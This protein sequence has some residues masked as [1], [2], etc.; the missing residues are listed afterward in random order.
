MNIRPAIICLLGSPSSGKSTII[1]KIQKDYEFHV[2]SIEDVLRNSTDPII[3]ESLAKGNYISAAEF[4]LPIIKTKLQNKKESLKPLILDGFPRSENQL[5]DYRKEFDT[6]NNTYYIHL[7]CS[8]NI[9][10]S[11][12][13]LRNRSDDSKIHE[14]LEKHHRETLLLLHQINAD[15][16]N[17]NADIEEVHTDVTRLIKV[18]IEDNLHTYEQKYVHY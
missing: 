10:I 5:Y 17:A 11:R 2:I 9:C 15:S 1:K 12:A 14:R 6:T 18:A 3:K 16:V 7:Q 8:D 13:S 4:I